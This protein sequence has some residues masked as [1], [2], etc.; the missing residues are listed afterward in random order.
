MFWLAWTAGRCS[1]VRGFA[2]KPGMKLIPRA[3]ST[4]SSLVNRT[5]PVLI[6][7]RP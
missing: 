7:V 1:D 5:L 3:M 4:P 2:S 6:T